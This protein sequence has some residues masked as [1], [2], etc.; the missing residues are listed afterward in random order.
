MIKIVNEVCYTF[1]DHE[2]SPVCCDICGLTYKSVGR[3]EAHKKNSH[4]GQTFKC[5]FCDRYEFNKKMNV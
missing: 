2:S 5:T 1:R 4:L 3:L